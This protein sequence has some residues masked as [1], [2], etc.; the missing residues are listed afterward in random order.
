MTIREQV[1]A[2]KLLS[3]VMAATDTETKNAALLKAADALEARRDEIFAA[4]SKDMEAAGKSGIK[5]AVIKRLKFDDGKLLACTEGLRQLASL[6]DPVGRITL[7]REMDQDLVL[8]RITVPIGVIGVIFEARPDAMVQ[9]S[10]LCIKSGNCAILKGGR[11]SQETCRVLFSVIREAAENAGLPAGALMQVSLH[12]EID[13]ILKLDEDV[14]LLIP[15]GSN[16][17]VRYIMDHTRIPVMGHAE[18]ICHIYVDASADQEMAV[19]VILDAKTTYPAACNAVET[20]LVSR[21]IA[22][23]FLPRLAKALADAQVAVRGDKE[24][25]GIIAVEGETLSD[26]DYHTEYGDL[27]LALKLVDG[28]DEAIRHIN[29]YGSR[30]TDAII[31]GEREPVEKFFALVD[32]AGVYHN[33]STRFADGFRYGFGAEVGIS[34]GKLHARGPVG[35]DGL[36]TYRYLIEGAGQCVG[37]YTEGRRSFHF[38]DL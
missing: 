22:G 36:T 33:C 30:H 27:T 7:K 6:P 15:R 25:A 11:E 1:H 18:G 10:G 5:E 32:S 29:A 17:F 13:E 38:R 21:T 37:E 24:V 3:P 31:A 14:D 26:S 8:S 9:I 35:L 19:R 12:E 20:V 28:V 16:A 2:M 23:E 34:T 4:N